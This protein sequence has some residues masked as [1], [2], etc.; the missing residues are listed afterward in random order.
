MVRVD[1]GQVAERELLL[2]LGAS[3]DN[4]ILPLF[5]SFFIAYGFV[6]RKMPEAEPKGFFDPTAAPTRAVFLTSSILLA[7]RLV[8]QVISAVQ[9]VT[10]AFGFAFLKPGEKAMLFL[11]FIPILAVAAGGYFLMLVAR[12]L[13]LRLLGE[14]EEGGSTPAP[15][16]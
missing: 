1:V 9:F 6:L 3:L 14:D 2:L 15:K 13:Y 12:R 7:Y 4:A 5:A 11:D 8:G 10:E 16:A